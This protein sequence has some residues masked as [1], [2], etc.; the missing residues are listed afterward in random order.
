MEH[1]FV[2]HTITNV[3]VKTD[4]DPEGDL[5]IEEDQFEQIAAEETS[6]YG[7]NRCGQSLQVAYGTECPGEQTVDD[8]GVALTS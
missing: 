8:E 4:P 7:C 6:V 3:E 1:Q 5:L 2:K